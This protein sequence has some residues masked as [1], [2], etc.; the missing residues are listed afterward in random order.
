[1]TVASAAI[2]AA[3]ILNPTAND[4]AQPLLTAPLTS[5]A[6]PPPDLR[7]PGP[8]A[9]NQKPEYD[10][11]KITN[12]FEKKRVRSKP[13]KF[14]LRTVRPGKPQRAVVAKAEFHEEIVHCF[15]T[16]VIAPVMIS[17]P[18]PD[19]AKPFCRLP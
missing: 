2:A 12:A 11:I 3:M 7:V 1:M 5:A 4:S 15:E 6:Y 10:E 18:D 13:I 8:S 9:K 17:T 16:G 19:P 14:R